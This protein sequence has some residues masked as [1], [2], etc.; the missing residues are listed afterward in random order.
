MNGRACEVGVRGASDDAD[1]HAGFHSLLV[2]V[3]LPI[4]RLCRCAPAPLPQLPI[5]SLLKKQQQSGGRRCA[6]VDALGSACRTPQS[7]QPR[8]VV[9]LPLSRLSRRRGKGRGTGRARSSGGGWR[10]PSSPRPSS[11]RAR[12]SPLQGDRQRVFF[13]S[14]VVVDDVVAL[15]ASFFF[16]CAPCVCFRR[17]VSRRSCVSAH[18]CVCLCRGVCVWGCRCRRTRPFSFRRPTPQTDASL[19]RLL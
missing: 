4:F 6:C 16:F 5:K 15:L 3:F 17:W 12:L 7:V 9:S 13:L 10:L 8:L 11:L 14:V 2:L 19:I 18:V 1:R